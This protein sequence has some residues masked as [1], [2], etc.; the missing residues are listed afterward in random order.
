MKT[1]SKNLLPK[2][3][4]YWEALIRNISNIKPRF[5]YN[6]G[7]NQK[8]D[9]KRLN[10]IL[11]KLPI[12]GLFTLT[13]L[14]YHPVL[15]FP[16]VQRTHVL[17]SESSIQTEILAESLPGPLSLP[18]PGYLST[19]FSNYHPGIDIAT[20][21]GMPIHPIT[22][23]VVEATNYSF[24]GLGNHVIISHQAG[25]KSTY[26]HMGRVY[27][28]IGQKVTI[29]STLGEVGLTGYTSGPHTHLEITRNGKFLDPLAILPKIPDFPRPKDFKPV[30]GSIVKTDLKK[31]QPDFK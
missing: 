2:N 31:L 4:S 20:G 3:L 13:L 8:K 7:E 30:G 28:K 24:W 9:F 23:G 11:F 26:A 12:I 27:V 16:P 25:Y 15:S 21:L 19:H 5:S 22:E 17:A 6:S 18:H 1:Y 29:D 10:N 14:G